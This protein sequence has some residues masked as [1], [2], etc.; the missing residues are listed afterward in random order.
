MPSDPYSKLAHHLH[1]LGMGY[2]LREELVGIL[3]ANFST[4]EAE[5]AL[6]VPNTRIPLERS[7]AEE[8]AAMRP[9]R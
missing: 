4:T 7:T 3:R 9:P 2:P 6:G 5:V 1:A 8:V